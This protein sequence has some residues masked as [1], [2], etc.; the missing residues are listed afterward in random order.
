MKIDNT[1]R[2]VYALFDTPA[3]QFQPASNTTGY[4]NYT[5]YA[6]VYVFAGADYHDVNGVCNV[7]PGV[8]TADFSAD[9]RA[10]STVRVNYI[11]VRIILR[12]EQY[13]YYEIT[14]YTM[15]GGSGSYSITLNTFTEGG[16]QYKYLDVTISVTDMWWSDSTELDRPII[17]YFRQRINIQPNNLSY[18]YTSRPIVL[19]TDN[20]TITAAD[21]GNRLDGIPTLRAATS[22]RA[23]G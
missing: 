9:R 8:P 16:T 23:D 5:R 6:N 10:Y 4:N 11:T 21:T 13:N 18:T 14:G 1:K 15:Q 12:P 7:A 19:D 20:V 22:P 2:N 17:V 3:G